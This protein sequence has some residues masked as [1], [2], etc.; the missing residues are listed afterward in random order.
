MGSFQGQQSQ[1]R[2]AG[3]TGVRWAEEGAGPWEAFISGHPAKRWRSRWLLQE[4]A[5]RLGG[6]VAW[7]SYADGGIH[8]RYGDSYRAPA[9][10]SSVTTQV[11]AI[12][13]ADLDYLSER[14]AGIVLD[15]AQRS[16]QTAR[17]SSAMAGRASA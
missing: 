16:I 9:V 1:I 15:G 11:Q 7:T 12:S 6:Q 4:V 2:P 3:G 13:R 5:A 10:A 14:L 17:R 8:A